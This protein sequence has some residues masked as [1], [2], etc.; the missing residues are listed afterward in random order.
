MFFRFFFCCCCERER[1]DSFSVPLYGSR[2]VGNIS[3]PFVPMMVYLSTAKQKKQK[4]KNL[5]NEP[6]LIYTTWFFWWY[7]YLPFVDFTASAAIAGQHGRRFEPARSCRN[8]SLQ[9][10]QSDRI[11]SSASPAAHGSIEGTVRTWPSAHT[12]IRL[13]RPLT[14]LRSFNIIRDSDR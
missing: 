2:A 7:H 9:V 11:E 5:S 14:L 12:T 1:F 13:N 6:N 10:D 8:D 4:Q 3:R